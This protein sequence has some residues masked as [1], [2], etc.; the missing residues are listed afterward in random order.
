MRTIALRTHFVCHYRHAC[1][2]ISVLHK[3]L[4]CAT[5]SFRP[6]APPAASGRAR[7]YALH[8]PIIIACM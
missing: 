2:C 7:T 6:M 5:M 3:R 8:V 1:V 4:V